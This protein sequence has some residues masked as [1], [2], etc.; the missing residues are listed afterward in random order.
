MA[1][2]A[3]FSTLAAICAYFIAYH[4]YR[5]QMLRPDQNPKRMALGTAAATLTFF[6]VAS[7]VLS[8]VL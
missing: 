6:L 3:V 1:I 2:G 7:F 4:E 5:Q 8:Q